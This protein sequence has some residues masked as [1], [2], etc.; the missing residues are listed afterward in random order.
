MRIF[1]IAANR[2]PVCFPRC[3]YALSAVIAGGIAL[4]VSSPCEAGPLWD[5]LF[6]R[7]NNYYYPVGAYYVPVTSVPPTSV[8][9][10]AGYAPFVPTQSSAYDPLVVHRPFNGGSAWSGGVAPAGVWIPATGSAPAAIAP[11]SFPTAPITVYS[12]NMAYAG[13]WNAPAGAAAGPC[14]TGICPAPQA[15]GPSIPAAVAY[16]PRTAYRTVWYRVPV[17][18]FRPT[19]VVNPTTGCAATSLAPCTTYAWQAR[20]VPAPSGGGFLSR[21]FHGY[22]ASPQPVAAPCAVPSG[23]AFGGVCPAPTGSAG[24]APT[25]PGYLVPPSSPS[26]IPGAPV[27]PSAPGSS[28][29]AARSGGTTIRDPADIPPSLDPNRYSPRSD[30][31]PSGAPPSPG[32]PAIRDDSA[33]E[34]SRRSHGSPSTSAPASPAVASDGLVRGSRDDR[35]TESPTGPDPDTLFNLQPVPDPRSL[36]NLERPFQPPRLL[37]PRDKTTS[38]RPAAVNDL[39]LASWREARDRGTE[40][41][42]V[43][44]SAPPSGSERPAPARELES[45][46]DDRGWRTQRRP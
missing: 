22:H 30:A 38:S 27:M 43:S 9:V 25:Y 45:K 1:A 5:A 20:R 12:S 23:Q 15:A 17:T 3:R 44:G 34:G 10:I 4:A 19:T 18:S 7:R 35:S 24:V 41:R 31:P 2:R 46:P 37:N 13:A 39:S 21:L 33:L 32:T 28:V 36:P 11:S 40:S 26:T 6:G 29:P 42:T 14:A 16:W 8:P